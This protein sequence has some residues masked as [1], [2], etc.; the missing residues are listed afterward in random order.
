LN[1][2]LK[3]GLI[4]ALF[5]LVCSC[6]FS[7]SYFSLTGVSTNVNGSIT[8][9]ASWTSINTPYDLSGPV[10]VEAGTALSIEHGVTVNLNGNTLLV[11]GILNANG[12]AKDKVHFNNGTILLD[13]NNS[14]SLIEN[15]VLSDSINLTINSGSPLISNNAINGNLTLLGGTPSIDHNNIDARIVVKGGSPTISNNVISDGIHA[16]AR[17]GP[18]EIINNQIYAKRGFPAVYVQGIHAD[19]SG[20]T[21][22]GN[23]SEGIYLY[24]DVTSALI[25][26]N[27]IYNFNT[28]I[29]V[30]TDNAEICGNDILNNALGL[31]LQ[32]YV[33]VHN[34]TI[35]QNTVGIKT[36]RSTINYNN[37]ENNTQLNMENWW[38]DD[39]DATNN[40]WG[41]GDKGSIEQTLFHDNNYSGSIQFEPFLD[42]PNPNAPPIPKVTETSI[43]R[44]LLTSQSL[45]SSPQSN[46][47]IFS[48]FGWL[49]IVVVTAAGVIAV[50]FVVAVFLRRRRP[51]KCRTKKT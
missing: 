37:F 11:K 29:Y 26:G 15:G 7:V 28:G 31:W 33:N 39:I 8:S 32:G 10:A 25:T 49:Q 1:I 47:S 6:A 40:W 16:D 12:T 34:N 4:A 43:P 30:F 2:K 14:S 46:T 38:L 20:N 18:A 50:V 3:A 19:I 22:I 21:L 51:H 44:E 35:A 36:N 45:G 48:G 42:A 23:G 27:E 5:V 41:T 24:L 9:D 17:G 13:S